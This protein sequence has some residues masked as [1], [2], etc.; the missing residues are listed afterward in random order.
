MSN[1]V[2]ES[3]GKG[4]LPVVKLETASGASCEICVYGGHVLS[5]R[6]ADGT[7][8][9]MVSSI[10][11]F[12][13][14]KAIR[15]G[16]PLCWPQFNERGKYSRHGF[17]R[18]SDFKVRRQ[19]TQPDPSVTLELG[20]TEETQAKYPF[21]F[22]YTLTVTL[23]DSKLTMNVHVV[24]QD[25]EPLDFTTALHTYFAV[26]DVSTARVLGLKGLQFESDGK[27]QTETEASVAITGFTDRIYYKTSEVKLVDGPR[28]VTIQKSESLPDAVVWNIGEE[29]SVE[30]KDLGQDEWRKYLC[31]EAGAIGDRVVVPPG[32]S[33]NGEQ[34]FISTMKVQETI[35][36]EAI[37]ETAPEPINEEDDDAGGLSSQRLAEIEAAF[38][39]KAK[40]GSIAIERAYK[41]MFTEE[42]KALYPSK[43]FEEDVKTR[44]KD[45]MAKEGEFSWPEAKLFLEEVG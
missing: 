1:A 35:S 24:N 11:D 6:T 27:T 5:W 25:D 37:S 40:G 14:G 2:T 10:A 45:K 8:Q 30:L 36:Q 34:R 19:R 7:E 20:A 38:E 16:I 23:E 13:K 22:V 41:V 26:S 15:G 28:T 29:R 3:L 21:S 44:F 43:D 33:W 39:A 31:V 12:Q 4:G 17:A 9:L 32:S 42:E 18:T